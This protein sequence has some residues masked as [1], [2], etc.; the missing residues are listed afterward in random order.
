MYLKYLIYHAKLP[1]ILNILGIGIPCQV[2]IFELPSILG[3]FGILGPPYDKTDPALNDRQK[4]CR[5]LLSTDPYNYEIFKYRQLFTK[6]SSVCK[7]GKLYKHNIYM[8]FRCS[9]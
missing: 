8:H 2:Y 6:K 5:Q 4:E 3:I 1:S 9:S 7:G